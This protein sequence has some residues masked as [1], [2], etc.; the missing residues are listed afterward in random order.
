MFHKF[1]MEEHADVVFIY[2][3]CEGNAT[4]TAAE[5][6]HRCPNRRI[7]NSKAFSGTFNMLRQSGSLLSVKN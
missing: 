7:Y 3:V 4:D 5:Y 2:S 6:Q 1:T